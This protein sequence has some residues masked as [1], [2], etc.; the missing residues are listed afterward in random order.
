MQSIS[1]S[2]HT[3]EFKIPCEISNIQLFLDEC[4]PCFF[5]N[6]FPKEMRQTITVILIKSF[7]SF[8][9]VCVYMS[10]HALQSRVSVGYL[11]Q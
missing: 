2:S 11:L 4:M 10:S 9:P 6:I 3:K 1:P 5:L 7:V 8:L